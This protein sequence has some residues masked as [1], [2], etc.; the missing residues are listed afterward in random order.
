MDAGLLQ[1]LKRGRPPLYE[2]DTERAAA[3]KRQK[4]MCDQSRKERVKN[5]RALLKE[6][7]RSHVEINNV[8]TM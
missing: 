4:Q 7:T 3:L 1:P 6:A 2:T 8:E 5:A